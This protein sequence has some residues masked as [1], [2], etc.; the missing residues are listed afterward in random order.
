MPPGR[1]A[2]YHHAD[3][4]RKRVPVVCRDASRFA[5]N[6]LRFLALRVRSCCSDASPRINPATYL[7]S[8]AWPYR[9]PGAAR[10]SLLITS[11]RAGFRSNRL[12]SDG[13]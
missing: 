4:R 8:S 3:A 7:A 9:P 12:Y 1:S 2:G 13:F 5:C 10:P 11:L 6:A